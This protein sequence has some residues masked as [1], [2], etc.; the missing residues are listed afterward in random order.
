MESAPNL[1][2]GALEHLA[3]WQI[4]APT[5][6]QTARDWEIIKDW[7]GADWRAVADYLRAQQT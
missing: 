5:A 7:T 2:A 4:P 6:E 3:L 1:P